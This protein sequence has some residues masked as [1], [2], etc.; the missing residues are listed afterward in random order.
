[1]KHIA[2]LLSVLSLCACAN[3][4]T[5]SV[6]LSPATAEIAQALR[7]A[8]ARWEAAGVDPDRIVIAPVG[9]AEGAPVRLVPERGPASETHV[10]FRGT[11][12]AGVRWIE[13]TSLDVHLVTHE[14]GHA[15]GANDS[16]DA[17]AC[18]LDVT[19]RPTMCS[20]V[21]RKLTAEDLD[22]VC[23]AGSCS[24]FQ[25]EGPML[26]HIEASRPVDASALDGSRLTLMVHDS[27]GQTPF[28]VDFRG[29]LRTCEQVADQIQGAYNPTPVSGRIRVSCEDG[30]LRLEAVEPGAELGVVSGSALP[31]LGLTGRTYVT[32]E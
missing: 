19:E 30:A 12:F 6:T 9:S 29:S 31:A 15:L 1:M 24:A 7:A 25:P 32:G 17:D 2:A 14:L 26:A 22:G 28:W 8:D 13:L 20:H 16:E 5:D 27:K 4:P 23:E 18:G 21:G 10:V 3:E 11:A